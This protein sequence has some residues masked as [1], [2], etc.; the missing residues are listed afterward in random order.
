MDLRSGMQ[1]L[2]LCPYWDQMG[3]GPMD[4]IGISILIVGS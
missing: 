4:V 2:C 1:E 3:E